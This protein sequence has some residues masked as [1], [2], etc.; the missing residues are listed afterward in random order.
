MVDPPDFNAIVRHLEEKDPPDF[1][2]AVRNLE[3]QNIGYT[4]SNWLS[5]FRSRI[6]CVI[7]ASKVDGDLSDFPVPIY[8]SSNTGGY[9]ST[10]V[11]DEVGG[12]DQKIAVTTSDGVTQCPVEI[13]S[14][15]SGA[16]TAE[17]HTKLPS[18][19]S[20]ADTVFYFY[21]DD[22]I[23]DNSSYVDVTGSTVAETVWDNNFKIV[24]HMND[25][26]DTS[27]VM[28]STSNDNDGAKT[29][30]N[31]PI[32]ASG[33]MEEGQDYDGTDD[34][35]K[36]AADASVN[37]GGNFTVE[38]W[39]KP[40]SI[41]RDVDVLLGH[42]NALDDRIG[43]YQ[44][45]DA[46]GLSVYNGAVYTKKGQTSGRVSAE[47]WHHLVGVSAA[48]TLTVYINGIED[49]GAGSQVNPGFNTWVTSGCTT[50]NGDYF[51]GLIDEIRVS[52]S[53]R[54]AAWAVATYYGL[55]CSLVQ[56]VGVQFRSPRFHR[57]LIELSR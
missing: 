52:A 47:A 43:L 37:V 20:S 28:D 6:K 35:I 29:A 16:K 1:D 22:N 13:V 57:A 7:P 42:V 51:A 3:R 45:N 50:A 17:L 26:P 11:F 23:A 56:F 55:D 18:I 40:D 19:S 38:L 15:D 31:E 8:L 25:N 46:A 30:A 36:H 10:Y 14:W 33:K 21:F 32:E 39:F 34:F 5:T 41:A 48:G 4:S 24:C 27:N 49:S 2:D 12:E 53:V 9:D 44:K 54:S